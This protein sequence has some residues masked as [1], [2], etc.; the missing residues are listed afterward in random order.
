MDESAAEPVNES[1]VENSGD[2]TTP[3][4]GTGKEE[5]AIPAPAPVPAPPMGR[6]FWYVMTLIGIMLVL[7]VYTQYQAYIREEPVVE[8]NGTTWTL[9][10]YADNNGVLHQVRNGTIVNATFGPGEGNLVGGRSGCNWYSANMSFAGS[11]LTISSF[12]TTKMNCPEPGVMDLEQTYQQQLTAVGSG[13]I[14]SG[15]LY[16]YD[17]NQKPVLIY[18]RAGE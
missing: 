3:K 16:F 2:A 15:L 13:Q 4:D 10:Q 1:P 6:A 7:I 18:N 11:Q 17:H 9:M 14:R 12:V 5:I 8:L